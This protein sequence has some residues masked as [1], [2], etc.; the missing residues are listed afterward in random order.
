MALIFGIGLDIPCE[1]CNTDYL[2][3]EL[4]TEG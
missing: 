4:D 2:V 1:K 3:T